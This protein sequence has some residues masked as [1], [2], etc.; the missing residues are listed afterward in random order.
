[1][2]IGTGTGALIGGAISAGGGIAQGLIGSNAASNAARSQAQADEFSAEL[3]A[4]TA[5]QALGFNTL[6]YQ[7]ALGLQEPTYLSGLNAQNA[8]DQLLG[9]PSQ[10][11]NL[12][13]FSNPLQGFNPNIQIP[14]LPGLPPLPQGFG[15]TPG[16]QGRPLG[17]QQPQLQSPGQSLLPQARGNSVSPALSGTGGLSSLGQSNI[18][19]PQGGNTLS[20]S[21]AAGSGFD[22]SR[23]GLGVVNSGPEASNQS[24]NG[25]QPQQGGAQPQTGATPNPLGGTG[26]SPGFLS[27]TFNQQFQAPTA[28]QAAQ[29]PGYQFQLQQGEQALQNSAAAQGNLLTGGTAKGLDEFSQGLAS[30]DYNN[31]FNQALQQYNTGFNVF[32]Q[33][34]ANVFNRFADLAG[35]APVSAQQLS[36]AGLNTANSVGNTLL[37]AGSQIGQDFTNAGAARA[38]GYVGGANAINGALGSVSNFASL[39]PFLGALNGNSANASLHV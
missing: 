13:I 29:F 37:G 21:P 27:Q 2:G 16:P 30:T 5:N 3:Q 36:N 28:D 38:S 34:Q 32:N 10:Q 6:Q 26:L 19:L 14:Q 22:A 15:S 39:L 17:N 20:S 33:N 4:Q 8:L 12:G 31:L 18:S 35:L 23:L 25:L 9:L 1:M 24:L 7:N 11:G